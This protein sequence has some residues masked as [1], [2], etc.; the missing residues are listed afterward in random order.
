MNE[1]L[2]ILFNINVYIFNSFLSSWQAMENE[3]SAGRGLDYDDKQFSFWNA[4]VLWYSQVF[5]CM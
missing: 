3:T 5:F 1:D 2:L 4:R